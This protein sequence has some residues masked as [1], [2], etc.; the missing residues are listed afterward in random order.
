M[1]FPVNYIHL[2]QQTCKKY[3]N[4]NGESIFI[5]GHAGSSL[6]CLGFL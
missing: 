3:C 5:F 1:C 2:K 6:L 4:F